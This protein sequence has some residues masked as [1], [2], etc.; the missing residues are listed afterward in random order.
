M[1]SSMFSCHFI[2]SFELQVSNC[3]TFFKMDV[4]SLVLRALNFKDK[5]SIR[6]G[7][8]NTPI[9]ANLFIRQNLSI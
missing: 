7:E 8:C 3:K 2:L 4:L 6:R 5:I 9:K 1:L